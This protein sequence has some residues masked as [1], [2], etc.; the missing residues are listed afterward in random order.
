[1]KNRQY[2]SIIDRLKESSPKMPGKDDF[3]LGV[4]QQ[5]PEAREDFSSTVSRVMFQWAKVPALR[6]ILSAAAVFIIIFFATQQYYLFRKMEEI[7]TLV[8]MDSKQAS[9]NSESSS[10][11]AHSF[12]NLYLQSKII[13]EGD[14]PIDIDALLQKNQRLRNQK[15]EI[16]LF[17]EHHPE[18]KKMVEEETSLFDGISKPSI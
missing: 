2:N 16:M 7:Q 4:M 10:I 1:M 13:N 9:W 12:V 18:I 14:T 11:N 6:F 15:D 8:I 17:L 3:V 5:I